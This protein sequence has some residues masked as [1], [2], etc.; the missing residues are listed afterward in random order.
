MNETKNPDVIVLA[1]GFGRRMLP[2]T[3]TTPKPLLEAG[4]RPLIDHVISNCMAEG[5]NR[6]AINAHYHAD[7][8]AAHVTQL[9]RRFPF[10]EFQLSEEPDQPLDTGGGVK[11]ALALLD[12]DPVLIANADAFWPT[13]DD[14][15]LA[16]LQQQFSKESDIVLLCAHPARALGFRRSHDFCLAPDKKITND[17]GMPVIYT[18][19][20]LIRRSLFADTPDGPFSL[21]DLFYKAGDLGRLHGVLLNAPWLHAGDPEALDEIDTMLR[22]RHK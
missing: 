16:R 14:K 8:I 22:D 17:R 19:V 1:A 3:E 20:A 2:L 5:C 21:V 15:P 4:R 10:A 13:G 12:S 18:G 6:F 11:K 7:Q 9:Q